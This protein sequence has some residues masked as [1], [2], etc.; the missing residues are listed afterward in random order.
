MPMFNVSVFE[1]RQPGRPGSCIYFPKGQGSPIIPPGIGWIC[2]EAEVNLRRTISRPV[3]LGVRLPTGAHDQIWVFWQLAGLLMWGALSDER[4]GL[5]CTRTIASGPCQ[6]F[7]SQVQ[8]SQNS[9]PY[10]TVSFETPPTWRANC[11]YLYHPGNRVVQ[12]CRTLDCSSFYEG[13]SSYSVA[14]N[15]TEKHYHSNPFVVALHIYLPLRIS[16]FLFYNVIACCLCCNPTEDN[17][18]QLSWHNTLKYIRSSPFEY[19]L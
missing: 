16:G 1:T 9:R 12:L 19:A 2:F 3:R 7:R 4:M 13:D 17:L 18:F 11:T 8:V 10:S 15:L 6:G 14:T 5:S